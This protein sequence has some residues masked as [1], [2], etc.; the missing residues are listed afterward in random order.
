VHAGRFFADFNRDGHIQHI[1]GEPNARVVSTPAGQPEKI[2]TSDKL[3]A[4]YTPQGAL[5]DVA[6]QGKFQYHEKLPKD[7][8]R[9]ATADTAHYSPT[10][11][12]LHLLG[13]PR[14]VEGGMSMTANIVHINRHTGE[15]IAEGD[16]KSTYSDLKAQPNGAMLASSD[17]IHVT[18]RK[19][20][21]HQNTGIALYTG[22]SRLWQGANIVEAPIIEF[23]RNNRSLVAEDRSHSATAPVTSVFVQ[24][25]KDGKLTPVNVNA[26]KLTYVD[27]ERRARYEGG[28]M[29][30]T[31]DGVLTADHVDIFLKESGTAASSPQPTPSQLDRIIAQGN[32][33]MAQPGRRGS[34]DKLTYF[35]DDGRFVLTG[36]S[37]VISDAEHG[38]VRGA[39]LTFFSKDDRVL[40][41]G[42]NAAPTVTH[43]RVSNK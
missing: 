15:A 41:E 8:E 32:V 23:N 38:T 27:A 17:P 16:V 26:R 7:G 19:M 25:D 31:T 30:R 13:S 3:E 9:I 20:T 28:V 35:Q 40:V 5:A 1:L 39:T 21:A 29:A 18:A 2:S 37:P 42:S 11:D 6:Q 43:T 10:D 22:G 4:F 14:I 34:G 33:I 12:M 24:K 36:G